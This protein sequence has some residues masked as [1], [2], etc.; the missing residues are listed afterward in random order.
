MGAANLAGGVALCAVEALLTSSFNS[1]E[2][3]SNGTSH[4]VSDFEAVLHDDPPTYE[5]AMASP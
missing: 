4:E 1:L 5:A 2:A 3:E